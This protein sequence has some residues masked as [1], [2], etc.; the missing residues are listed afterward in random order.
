LGFGQAP[1]T[2]KEA[3][4][5]RLRWARG[6][7]ES[8]HRYRRLLLEKGIKNSDWSKLDAVLFTIFPSYSTLSLISG[9]LLMIHL[10]FRQDLN[11]TL[12]HIWIGLSFICL[13]YPFFGLFLEKAP[14]W[15]YIALI[16]GAFF[17][18]WRT[19]LRFRM[20]LFSKKMI[21]VR[22]PHRGAL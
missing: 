11:I 12:L 19:Y 2:T 4:T 13:I 18:L 3:L 9:T 20:I 14:S 8:G 10:Y 21:W 1:L 7:S 5:Q 16:L 17:I 15:A 6:V 22:T